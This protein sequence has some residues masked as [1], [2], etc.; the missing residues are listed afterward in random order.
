VVRHFRLRDMTA[1]GAVAF[2]MLAAACSSST[3]STSGPS[4]T[5]STPGT[6]TSSPTG[7]GAGVGALNPGTGTPQSGGTLNEVG[8]SDV[9]FLD[10]DV[11][12]YSTDDMVMRLSVRSLY[13]WG[14]TQATATTAEPDLATGPPVVTDGGKTVTITLR[15][16]VEWD[17]TPARAVTAADVARGIKRACNPSPVAFGGMADFESTIVGLTA[18]CHGYPAASATSASVMKAYIEGHNVPGIIASGNTLTLKLTQ[19]AAWLE[20]AMTLPPFSG[21][22]IEAESALPGSPGIYNHMYADGP[23]KIT[24]YIPKK[25]FTFVRNPVWNASTDPLRK[26]YVNA[27]NVDETGDQTT[28]YQEITTN[29]PSLGLTWDSRP[30]PADDVSLTNAMKSGSP[31]VGLYATY[32]SNPYIVFNTVSPNNG[33]ALGKVAVRQALSYGL[34][35]SQMLKTLGG[36]TINPP[37]THILPPGTD[38]AQDVPAGY[39]PYP[40]NPTKATAMLTAAGFTPSHKLVLKYLY[41]SDSQ[42]QT[43]LFTNLSAQLSALGN[44]SVVGVP[45]NQSDFYGKYLYNTASPSP[46]AKGVWDFVGAGWSPDWYG[47]SAVSWFNPLLSA[48]G[49]FPADGGS[50]FGFFSDP[51]VNSLIK[52]ALLQ[53]TEPAADTYWAK[54]DEASM[55]AAAIY[56]ITADLEFAE[57]AAYVHNAVYIPEL[58]QY[59]AANVWLSAS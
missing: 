25:S 14:N 39:D 6:S 54:A 51:T 22:P 44:V 4:S 33:G 49:G 29:T 9:E 59:D 28:I 19:P 24:S 32:S 31:T 56:P 45:T 13:S 34:D 37:L 57:H 8:V 17:T 21:V 26:A 18:F 43:Q 36:A 15:S 55:S 40:Y 27:I 41:R 58:Q 3:S 5:S 1:V 53:T 11:A 47:N 12:Y 50:N 30:P 20:G 42:G 2:V 10:Y 52:T 23:Y 48:P 7:T 16:G 35:R 38:G 46:A